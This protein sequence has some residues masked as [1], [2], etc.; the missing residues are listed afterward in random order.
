MNWLRV[1]V[2]VV[3]A[4][5]L[6]LA[7]VGAW[8]GYQF[9]DVIPNRD[10]VHI[11]EYLDRIYLPNFPWETGYAYRGNEHRLMFPM[12]LYAVDHVWFASSGRF[13]IL[14][15]MALNGFLCLTLIWIMG[16][17][18]GWRNVTP[19][20]A[21]LVAVLFFWPA[22]GENVQFPV[23][24]HF[25]IAILASIA[26]FVLL[27]DKPKAPGDAFRPRSWRV[28]LASLSLFVGTFSFGYGMAAW[29]VLIG[30]GLVRRWSL[31][32]L[33]PLI[34]ALAATAFLFFFDWPKR[35][36]HRSPLD[37]LLWPWDMLATTLAV[38]GAPI[39]FIAA[40][41]AG[42]VLPVRT[43][44]LST[45][46]G[47]VAVG[48]LLFSWA[49]HLGYRARRSPGDQPIS[50]VPLLL[51]TFGLGC[52]ALIGY[53]R[54]E[55]GIGEALNHRYMITG[56]LLWVGVGLY[57]LHRL[58][59][60]RPALRPRI[61][62][63]AALLIF[64]IGLGYTPYVNAM[65]DRALDVRLRAITAVLDLD[66]RPFPNEREAPFLHFDRA[67]VARFIAQIRQRGTSIFRS[68]WAN[69]PGT[70]FA[71]HFTPATAG[72]CLGDVRK[73]ER[74]GDTLRLTGWAWNR[75]AHR[76]PGWIVAV[77]PSGR[78]I[79]LGTLGTPVEIGDM[80]AARSV[81]AR[82]AGWR[83]FARLPAGQSATVHAILADGRACKIGDIPA[84]R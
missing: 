5:G 12:L 11:E 31:R 16:R 10:M 63:I 39:G 77:G 37:I 22:H 62:V 44:S 71:D 4:Y 35:P 52:A 45:G 15:I 33:A 42:D 7:A 46:A 49:D 3:A 53:G 70:R 74:R 30:Y 27:D 47:I 81:A 28:I 65:R 19:L 55:H 75:A 26:A 18:T 73:I 54:Q 17:G 36:D 48:I 8:Y 84:G 24:V 69:W 51:A 14:A 25:Y 29:P 43:V 76:V 66:P 38:A 21:A 68:P 83:G 72:T 20:L 34:A 2:W 41:W 1:S 57:W 32:T 79:G 40:G 64:A 60:A 59:P 82:F 61:S 58:V 78:V 80:V 23:Q 13:L 56:L 9:A 6:G 50:A 67:L